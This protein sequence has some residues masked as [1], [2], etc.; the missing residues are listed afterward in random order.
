MGYVGAPLLLDSKNVLAPAPRNKLI[1]NTNYFQVR[2]VRHHIAIFFAA[3]VAFL[4]SMGCANRGQGP[5][6]GPQD[7]TPPRM[8]KSVPEP[9]ALN[10]KSPI[11]EITFDEIVQVESPFEKVVISPPQ[12][13][14]AVIKALGHKVKVEIKDSLKE[15]TTYTIDFTDAI[16]DNNEGNKLEGFNLGFST[17]SYIDSLRISG[18]VVDAENLNPVAGILVGI[19]S[20]LHDSALTSVPFDRISKTNRQGEFTIN[21]IAEGKYRVYAL[22][23]MGN[24]YM[25]DI[26]T[27]RI[28]FLDSVYAPSAVG[29]TVYDT[30]GH[31]F[32]DSIT[33]VVDSARFIVDTVIS[34]HVTHYSPDNVL[35]QTFIE[36]DFRYFLVRNERRERSRFS[37]IFSSGSDSL[38]QLK[39]IDTPDSVL[40]C[41]VQRSQKSDTITY[42]IT[43]TLQANIDTLK[44]QLKYYRIDLDTQY[45]RIDTLSLIYRQPKGS[46]SQ[47]GKPSQQPKQSKLSVSSNASNSFDVYVPLYITLPAPSVV[48]DTC[49]FVLQQKVDTLYKDIDN[50]KLL[51]DDSIGVKFKL[52][53]KW[54]PEVSYKLILDS[55]YFLA[56]DGKTSHAEVFNFTVK[57]L[58]EY[59]KIIFNIVDY[60]GVEVIQ[61]LDKSDNVV[62][63][64]RTSGPTTVV[65]YLT[66]GT[67]YA[68][69]LMDANHNGKWDT[70]LYS[71]H[72]Q[73]E[74]IYYFPYEIELRAFW[75]V[76][77]DWD[78]NE[79]PL[80]E[81][82]P[83]VLYVKQN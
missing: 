58:E 45:M 71:E 3:V 57:S 51:Q 79:L 22:A 15:N 25:F 12:S 44:C 39:L 5:Q 26:P 50:V 21:N 29:E 9:D 56:V 11:M 64:V 38:P 41:I 81:Q 62:R 80:I 19:H 7:I 6:G 31:L 47:R 32:T 35:L 14:P 72:R 18:K 13:T 59:G 16:K 48:N 36:E 40:N 53:Y 70:G 83:K 34:R 78:I 67:Y 46:R 20:L 30:I 49:S 10:V 69:L 4:L 77:E 42:W 27:E 24:N 63:Q 8:L 1:I 37:L 43:D 28:A 2:N 82:K 61:L 17:G 66:P 60:K 52:D 55:A 54:Q 65:E 73:P 75:E 23:D 68:R 74:Q 76:E 33:G